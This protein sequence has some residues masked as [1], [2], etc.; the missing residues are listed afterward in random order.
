MSGETSNEE[1]TV[2][3]VASNEAAETAEKQVITLET[4][5]AEISK[6]ISINKELI[7]SRDAAKTKLRE[8]EDASELQ[9]TKVEQ[10][11][12]TL[13]EIDLAVDA[14]ELK[15]NK[16]LNDV[17]VNNALEKELLTAGARNIEMAKKLLNMKDIKV[18]NGV[19]DSSLIQQSVKNLK[20][21]ASYLFASEE[22]GTSPKPAAMS[23]ARAGEPE[24][25]VI[26]NEEIKA[27]TTTADLQAVMK[28]H[29]LLKK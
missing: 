16:R 14:V 11:E 29:G 6:V 1:T 21:A 25:V 5:Q 7:A 22:D 26:A 2:E 8:A 27:T 3:S 13:G 9:A 20:E 10:R 28:K 23:V 19:A 15:L 12:G 24:N 18:V 4:L 17:L